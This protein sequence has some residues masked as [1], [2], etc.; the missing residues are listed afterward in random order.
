MVAENKLGWVGDFIRE[1]PRLRLRPHSSCLVAF[2]GILD[3]TA[4]A[5]GQ[6]EITDFYSLD[7]IVPHDFPK[8]CPEVFE[9]G[10]RIP[11]D[12]KYHK[13][14]DGSLCL[15]SPLR[16]FIELS[17]AP[18]LTAYVKK[19][20]IPYLYA[21]SLNLK[22]GCP[23]IFGELEH[24]FPGVLHDYTD[25]FG[26]KTVAQVE[27]A[28]KLLTLR[29][30]LA[31]KYLCPCGCGLKLGACSFRRRLNW[32]RELGIADRFGIEK[33]IKSLK[34]KGHARTL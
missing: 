18:K 21:M 1:Y 3:F 24:G 7:I 26:V 15:G 25:I 28:L 30:R 13:N 31:N 33:V 6:P 29:P 10:E 23:F 32:L 11:R 12:S 34:A 8:S 22:Y 9:K 27:L 4:V 19:C 16:L 2:S 17:K 14:L 5:P 20:L